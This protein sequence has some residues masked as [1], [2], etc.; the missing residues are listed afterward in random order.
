MQKANLR[1]R[2]KRRFKVTNYSKHNL[3]VAKNLLARNFNPL[4]PNTVWVSDISYVKTQE[5]WLYLAVIIDLYS[6][7]IVGWAMDANMTVDLIQNALAMAIKKRKPAQNYSLMFHSDRG[8]QY[9]SYAF[10]NSLMQNKIICSMSRTGNCWDN[11]VAESFFKTIKTELIYHHSY[12]NRKLAIQN[13]FEYIE[14]FYNRIRLH[15]SL[16]YKTPMQFELTAL[17]S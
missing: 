1:A 2:I 5:G 16:N 14:V 3:P 15:S 17:R 13:I 9:A 6:R 10:Q 8:S 4:H 11:A 7:A 12:L